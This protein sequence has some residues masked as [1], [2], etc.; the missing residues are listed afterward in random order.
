MQNS[1]Y[2]WDNMEWKKYRRDS[3][4]SMHAM[5]SYLAMFPPTLPRF[6]IKT[7]SNEG[8]VIFDPFSGRGTTAFEAC[9]NNRI[10]IGNDLNPLATILTSAKTNIPKKYK[11]FKRIDELELGYKGQNIENVDEHIKVLFDNETT[12]PQLVY[13]KN[14]LDISRKV[15]RFIM[16][17]LLGILH[18]KTRKDGTSM[19]LSI[20]M[21]NTFS[22]SPNYINKYINEHKLIPPKQNVFECLRVRLKNLFRDDLSNYREGK[23]YC[24]DAVKINYDRRIFKDKSVDLIITSPPYLKVINYGTYNW[25]R[26]WM[27]NESSKIV[28]ER[29]K[30]NRIFSI[31]EDLKL[32]DNLVLEKYL[33]FMKDVILGW[34]RI[35]KDDGMAFV[36]IGD[37]SNYNGRYI[38]LAN[39]VWEFIRGKTNLNFVDIIEDPIDNKTKVTKIWGNNKKGNATKIDRILILS[40]DKPR[41]PNINYN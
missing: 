32:K 33:E 5:C 7:F 21:P 17:V 34:E 16:A 20:S 38:K 14:T 24:K 19:Y 9:I 3:I 2:I 18:G 40:K 25:I 23:S 15:D 26:L 10:G 36:V 29:L 6:F 37:V 41:K 39:E 4:H 22:M 11:I 31:N 13:L 1:D 35:L 28:D 12:L 8:D 27:L 30:Q